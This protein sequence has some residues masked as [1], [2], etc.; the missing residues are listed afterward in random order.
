MAGGF[1]RLTKGF[2]VFSN[3]TVAVLFLLGSYSSLFDPKYFWFIGLFTF[4]SIYLLLALLFFIIFWLFVKKK[5]MLISIVAMLLAWVPLRHLVKIKIRD[6]FKTAKITGNLR[7]MS[8]N[9]EHFN[10]LEHKTHPEKK[11]LM[12]DL[13]N[14]YQPDIACFQEMVGSEKDSNAINYVPFLKQRLQFNN[15]FYS[16][17]EKLDF[18]NQHHFGIIIFSKYPIIQKHTISYEPNTYNSIFQYVDILKGADTFRV[19]NLHLQSMKFSNMNRK[20]IDGPSL[21]DETDLKKSKN[22]L[23][24][25]KTAFLKRKEQTDRIKLAMDASPY[26]MIVCGDFN[27]VPNSYAYSKIGKGMKNSFAEKGSGIGR[28]FSSISPTLRIDNIFTD[29]RFTT[30]QF[31]RV[32]KDLSDHFPIIADLSFRR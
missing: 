12:L 6:D 2:F 1:R 7:V 30:E 19:F 13:I 25:F 18:D 31:T 8:W 20:Y 29:D 27:D 23:S 24:K 9:I 10:I 17:N 22:I 4:A 14:R 15:Y 16:Y 32:K 11:A 26:P 5:F 21:K 28:T 3:F